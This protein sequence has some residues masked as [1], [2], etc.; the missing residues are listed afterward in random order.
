MGKNQN[1]RDYKTITD[2]DELRKFAKDEYGLVLRNMT[3]DNMHQRIEAA[4]RE[5]AEQKRMRDMLERSGPVAHDNT[6]E[7]QQQEP[8]T[9][10]RK[11]VTI[12]LPKTSKDVRPEFVGV[13][14]VGYTIPRGVKVDVPAEVVHVLQNAIETVI[15]P[16][17]M[18]ARDV[19]VY[20]IQVLS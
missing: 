8:V 1:M 19:P 17:T 2:P 12:I 14:G 4:E 16:E 3:I 6:D 13:N 5:Q 11:M 10:G 7:E 15:D 20:P 9:T 18:E